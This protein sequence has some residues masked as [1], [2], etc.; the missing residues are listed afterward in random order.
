MAWNRFEFTLYNFEDQRA[1]V[2]G[3]KGV[4]ES[5]ELVQDTPQRPNVAF[6]I[7]RFFLTEFRT[8]VIWG[9]DN[10]VGHVRRLIEQFGDSQVSDL[11]FI[12]LT[13]KH[14]DSF[15]VTVEDFVSVQVIQ[16]ETHLNEELPDL[17]LVKSP[18]HLRLEVLAQ[19]S[20]FAV[21]HDDD[22]VISTEVAVVVLADVLAVDLG[23]DFGLAACL[24]FLR[25]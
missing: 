14:V 5:T 6:V 1:L 25:V 24:V 4:L 21:F 7:I 19:V 16:A 8:Q 15:D 23:Q 18:P 13:Q 3:F 12:V 2:V 9:A 10:C 22:D 17:G 20:I 11:D